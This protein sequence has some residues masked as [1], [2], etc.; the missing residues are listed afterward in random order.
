MGRSPLIRVEVDK[1]SCLSS[2]RCVARAP[3]AFRLDA[4]F[5]A[6]ATPEATALPEAELEAI[7][8]AC[9]G[10]AIALYRAGDED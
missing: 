2:E 1:Q 9:P 4:D 8:R 6:E 3:G 10:L 7:A 5:L